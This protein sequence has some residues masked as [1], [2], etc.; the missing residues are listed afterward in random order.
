M[1]SMKFELKNGLRAGM[2]TGFS[3]SGLS[4]ANWF[5]AKKVEGEI[6]TFQWGLCLREENVQEC[7]SPIFY[8]MPKPSK[9]SLESQSLQTCIF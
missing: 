6:E 4:E 7:I 1:F 2:A 9:D 8:Q 3:K 5:L